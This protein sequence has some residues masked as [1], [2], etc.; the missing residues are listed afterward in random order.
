[1]IDYLGL[2]Q[3]FDSK[4]TASGSRTLLYGKAGSGK[5]RLAS[6]WPGPILFIDTDRGMRSIQSTESMKF[7]RFPSYDP[8]KPTCPTNVPSFDLL[9][10]ILT[11]AKNGAGKFAPGQALEKIKTIVI[12]GVSA[13]VDEFIMK[14]IMLINKRDPVKDK[15]QFDDY[16]QLKNQLLQFGT[17]IKD[18]SDKMYIVG[19]ALVN[20]EKDELS[21]A[22][23]GKPLITGSYRDM[24]GGVFDEEYFLESIDIGGGKSKYVL[25]A[26]KYK[27]YEAKTRL[28]EVTTIEDATFEK[29][30]AN[31]RNGGTASKVA[32]S[33]VPSYTVS[34]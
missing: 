11:D 29:I 31:Y 24:I 21:G 16:G 18:L 5:T 7:I 10:Q 22:F 25:H 9:M 4:L 3:D 23:Q 26:S 30:R 12:D 34:K 17:I 1:V 19:T 15:A 6:T 27:W 14:E 32:P 8:L 13:L 20:E 28:L 33:G 2:L